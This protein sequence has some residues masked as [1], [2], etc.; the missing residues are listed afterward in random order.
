MDTESDEHRDEAAPRAE[1]P[2]A[3][4]AA[5]SESFETLKRIVAGLGFGAADAQDILQDV[6]VQA[7]QRGAALPAGQAR[8]WLVRVTVN[9]GLLEHRQ[10]KRFRRATARILRERPEGQ[11]SS[12]DAL[13]EK[14]EEAAAVRQAMRELDEPLLVV[15]ALRYSSGMD[16]TEIG[17][18]LAIPPA[19]V[20]RRLHDARLILARRLMERGFGHD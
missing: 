15:M 20:R 12:P 19:T 1:E 9:R 2:I 17:E 4:T 16:S 18:A 6:Y 10:R 13:A 8:A 3:A 5:F 14:A 7:S 11:A